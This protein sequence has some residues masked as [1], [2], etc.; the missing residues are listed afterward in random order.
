M[1]FQIRYTHVVRL[2]IIHLLCTNLCDHTVP[3]HSSVRFNR[4][5]G[6]ERGGILKE[7]ERERERERESARERHGRV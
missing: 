6:R 4:K 7:R 2:L 3:G 5:E 1:F